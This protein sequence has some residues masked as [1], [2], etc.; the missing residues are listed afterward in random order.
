MN[1]WHKIYYL[2]ITEIGHLVNNRIFHKIFN[3]EIILLK[4]FIFHSKHRLK[5][6]MHYGSIGFTMADQNAQKINSA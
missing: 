2:S 6:L 3:F 5:L 1:F 4:Y